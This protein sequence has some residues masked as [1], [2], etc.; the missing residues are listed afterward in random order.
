MRPLN[1][2]IIQNNLSFYKHSKQSIKMRIS[3]LKYF[4]DEKY[5]NY[6]GH[7]FDI[8]IRI[9]KKYFIYLKNL[10]TISI[11]TRKNKWHILASFL[12]FTMED[13][14]N[15]HVAI[16]RKTVSWN[17]Y[18]P[19]ENV[20]TNKDV[21]AEKEEIKKI[22][23]HFEVN[24]FKHYLIFK[25]L[26]ET[27]MRKGELINAK[28]TDVN[29]KYRHIYIKEGK[30]GEKI[31]NFSKDTGNKLKLYLSE[32]KNLEIDNKYLFLTKTLRKYDNRSFNLILKGNTTKING[33]YKKYPGALEK[34][35]INKNITCKTFRSTLNTLRKKEMG[36]SNEVA[37]RLLGHKTNDVNIKS[38]TKYDFLDLI[39][40]FDK[41]N[42]YQTLN[43]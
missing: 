34:L 11:E 35:E 37:K 2:E 22:L 26:V 38:Y 1:E 33:K 17:G 39:D 8:N 6:Q 10:N 21:I 31:Y 42:P 12:N 20:K 16:P 9:L 14:E 7:I 41:Y 40:L 23:N 36:C 27:G 25:I 28:Y 15:F 19:K 32:R 3:S 18:I 30:T 4:F 29:L 13:Y 43:L 5:F 24:N